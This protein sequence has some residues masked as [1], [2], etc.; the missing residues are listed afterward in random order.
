MGKFNLNIL[1]SSKG[2]TLVELLITLSIAAIL[3]S[4]A[5]PSFTSTI[6]NNRITTQVNELISSL[7]YARSEAVSRGMSISLNSA[8]TTWHTGWEIQD[9]ASTVFRNHAAFEGTNSLI[10]SVDEITYLSSG[11][12]A[13]A[14]EIEFTL[15]DNNQDSIGRTILISVTGR[16]SVSETPCNNSE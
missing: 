16:A 7:S 10:G 14:D 11:F 4:M 3:I 6:T 8:S 2:F 1:T 9:N 12:L 5:V 13:G 15:C